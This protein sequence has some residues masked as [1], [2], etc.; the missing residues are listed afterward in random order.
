MYLLNPNKTL[1]QKL[2][3]PGDNTIVACYG[4]RRMRPDKK[5][6][7]L[8]ENKPQSAMEARFSRDAI[9]AHA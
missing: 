3:R 8:V 4:N 6:N 9:W 1:T 7:Y 2:K 5:I